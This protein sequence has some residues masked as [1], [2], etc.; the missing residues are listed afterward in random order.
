VE[1]SNDSG[2]GRG[3]DGLVQRG[4]EHRQDHPRHRDPNVASGRFMRR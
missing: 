1:F 3:H 2:H 4:H